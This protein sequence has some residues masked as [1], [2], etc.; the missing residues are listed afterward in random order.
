[1]GI[2]VLTGKSKVKYQ[3]I[4]AFRKRDRTQYKRKKILKRTLII[5][6]YWAEII[7]CGYFLYF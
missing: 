7:K 4:V 1:M 6:C 3:R 2:R 5:K